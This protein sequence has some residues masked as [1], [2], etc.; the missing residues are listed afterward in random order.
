VET[1]RT[2]LNRGAWQAQRPTNRKQQGSQ[3]RRKQREKRDFSNCVSYTTTAQ[4]VK[5]QEADNSFQVS[6]PD[7]ELCFAVSPH[8]G[9]HLL[10][11]PLPA[12]R[13]FFASSSIGA[14]CAPPATPPPPPPPCFP[15]PASCSRSP[16]CSKGTNWSPSKKRVRILVPIP[17]FVL[18]VCSSLCT[19][20]SASLLLYNSRLFASSRL[21]ESAGG[22]SR[23]CTYN[24][25][26]RP[27]H[28]RLTI[29][30]TTGSRRREKKREEQKREKIP[31]PTT[32]GS[33]SQAIKRHF[34]T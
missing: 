7:S 12:C 24:G 14:P 21:S 20:R 1:K 16:H 4:G 28:F 23:T 33:N 27:I 22:G 10:F 25:T 15:I 2:G 13:G 5:L 8:S 31:S 34:H 32:D 19:P 26:D 29:A 18:S 6:S 3:G 9:V 30:E 17:L 11:L